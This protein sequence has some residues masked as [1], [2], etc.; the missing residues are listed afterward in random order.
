MKRSTN[1]IKI[2]NYIFMCLAIAAMLGCF[3]F[4]LFF[5]IASINA[6]TQVGFAQFIVLLILCATFSVIGN[7]F[8]YAAGTL[9]D[10]VR[11]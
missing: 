2:F 9:Y 11:K 3:T 8:M 5:G 6:I 10:N 1:F 4:T 7:G